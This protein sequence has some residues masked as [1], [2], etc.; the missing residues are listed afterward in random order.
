MI[1]H[2]GAK[3]EQTLAR[4]PEQLITEIFHQLTQPLTSLHCCLELCLNK[5][6]HSSKSRADLQIALQQAEKIAELTAQLRELVGPDNT[7]SERASGF[8]REPAPPLAW[9]S[10]CCR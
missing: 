4:T 5:M 9:P 8:S 7:E 3:N 6:P 1:Q 10:R 2:D